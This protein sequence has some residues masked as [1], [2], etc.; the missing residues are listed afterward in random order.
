[1]SLCDVTVKRD[2]LRSVMDSLN[3]TSV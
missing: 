2:N 3:W 1:M